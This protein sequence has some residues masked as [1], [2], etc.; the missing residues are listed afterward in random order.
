MKAHI[1]HDP[2]SESV[3]QLILRE[4]DDMCYPP[5][6]ERAVHDVRVS[7]KRIRAWLRLLRDAMGPHAYRKENAVVRDLGQLLCLRRDD[8][9][10]IE[11]LDS[12]ARSGSPAFAAKEVTRLKALMDLDA[13]R[14]GAEVPFA[15]VMMRVREALFLAHRR[16]EKLELAQSHPERTFRRL[17]KQA[18][19]AYRAA[20]DNPETDSLHEWRKQAK[21]L[22]YQ[23][24]A[25]KDIWPKRVARWSKVLKAQAESL[26]YDHDLAVL[27]ERLSDAAQIEEIERLRNALQDRVLQDARAFYHPR[28]KGVG[29]Q[30]KKRWKRWCIAR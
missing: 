28:P 2:L 9:V 15:E 1:G 16:V 10:V 4:M 30:L 11:T 8:E 24:E 17:W 19:T 6:A 25:L 21:Y 26:G 29:K 12:L 23:L 20:R 18:R 5:R 14:T 27:A 13:E 7:G 22:R 3:S